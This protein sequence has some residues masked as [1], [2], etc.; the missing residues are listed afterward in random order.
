MDLVHVEGGCKL[1][2]VLGDILSV[3]S[4]TLF[5]LMFST[6]QVLPLAAPGALPL[7]GYCALADFQL[8]LEL[9]DLLLDSCLDIKALKCTASALS[10]GYFILDLCNNRVELRFWVLRDT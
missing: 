1:D 9:L 2:Y 8:L 4:E 3:R 6:S 7:G 5:H 10:L